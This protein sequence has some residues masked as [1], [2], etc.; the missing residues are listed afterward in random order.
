M[1][2]VAF[3]LENRRPAAGAAASFLFEDPVSRITAVDRDAVVPALDALEAERARGRWVCGYVA[4]E[5]AAAFGLATREAAA[6]GSGLAARAP[7][8]EPLPL[9]DFFSFEQ[10]RTLDSEETLAWLAAS[11]GDGV[12]ECAIFGV[13]RTESTES[14]LAKIARIHAYIAAGDTYQANFTFQYRFGFEGSA[15]SLYRALR[16]RQRVEL[17]AYARLPEAEILSFS[18]ELF[19]RRD[20]GAITS[21]PMKGTA[22]RGSSPDED[23]RIV[24]AMRADPKTLSENLM[25]VDLIR[26]D[27]GRVA[28]TGSVRTNDL[29][30]VQAFETVHQMIS[31]VR[32]EL[33][34]GAASVRTILENLFPCG[35][36]TG[37]PKVRTME[38][39]RELESAP[40]GVYT[41]AIGFVAPGG[42]FCFSVPIRTIVARG[43]RAE[44]GVGS[45]IVHDSDAAQELDECVLKARFLLG[46][47]GAFRLVESVCFDADRQELRRWNDHM[48]RMRA[49]AAFFSF[50]FDR[51]RVLGEIERVTRGCA[52]GLHKVRVTLAHD[53]EVAASAEAL[54]EPAV[55]APAGAAAGAETNAW[56]ALSSARIDSGS[57]F[58]R[59][60]TTSRRLYEDEYR[61][62]HAKGAYDVLFL[63][64]RGEL[65]EASR[66]NVFVD[67]GGRWVTP[68][69]YSGALA[70]IM[71]RAVLADRAWNAVEEPVSEDELR[72]AARVF[73]TNSVRGVVPVRLIR[74]SERIVTGPA[75]FLRA[76]GNDGRKGDR[77]EPPRG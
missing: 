49:S 2:R 46:V 39:L 50:A 63:N 75:P 32:A 26:N 33:A 48:E 25:I 34:D 18:P 12:G 62:W 67:K 73:L 47:N 4:Y 54:G 70:G 22:P 30:E 57:C 68:P 36:V 53:G 52:A 5:A 58:R 35:S 56:V 44:M 37:A 21:K 66:H 77:N 20:G 69:V 38:I 61:V 59:H 40:R 16:D 74:A 14:Y 3:L 13:E 64:E 76:A 72:A 31:T 65:A 41:G 15:L 6:V 42:D 11:A 9:V 27:F 8:A 43:Q 23:A 55:P 60:K 10:R 45:G 51:A 19:M 24:A 1:T 7:A 71:R 17:G 28:K 29:F